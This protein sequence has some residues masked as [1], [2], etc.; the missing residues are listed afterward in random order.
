MFLVNTISIRLVQI[1]KQSHN[2]SDN[3]L[4]VRQFL[5]IPFSVFLQFQKLQ[6]K[7]Q[8]SFL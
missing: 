2:I 8:Y 7:P 1:D 5:K 3:L 4:Q 6:D